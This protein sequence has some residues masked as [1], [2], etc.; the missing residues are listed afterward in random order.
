M[1]RSTGLAPRR[2]YSLDANTILVGPVAAGARGRVATTRTGAEQILTTRLESQDLFKIVVNGNASAAG[3][4]TIQVAHVPE[5]SSTVSAYATVA[6]VT[7]APG[8]QEIPLSGVNIRE[9][10][11]VAGSVTG[12]VRAVAVRAVA[13]TAGDAPAGVSTISL[14][15]AS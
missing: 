8:N 7:C 12:D 11:R 15:Y 14:Q 2:G 5:G 10:V 4:Y 6:V 3:K 13:G 1:S 9:L